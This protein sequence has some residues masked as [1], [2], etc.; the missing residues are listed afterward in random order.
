VVVNGRAYININA[1]KSFLQQGVGS[2]I[3]NDISIR[4]GDHLAFAHYV[5]HNLSSLGDPDTI[6]IPSPPTKALY[7][8][9]TVGES[10]FNVKL[11]YVDEFSLLRGLTDINTAGPDCEFL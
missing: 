10:D 7:F 5:G 11:D 1:G 3:R 4:L 9:Y 2:N 6:A 8:K